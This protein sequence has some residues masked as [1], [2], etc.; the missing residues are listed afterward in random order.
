M[1]DVPNLQG[2]KL[3]CASAVI[4]VF[5][6]IVTGIVLSSL[7]R[8]D[9]GNVG[10]YFKYGALMDVTTNPGIHYMSPFV[11]DV[12]EVMIRPQTD[13]LP[14]ISAIT[15]DGIQNTFND[16]QVISRIKVKQL[17]PMI[18]T[19]GINFRD[20]LINDR[21]KEELRIF[22]ANH[23]IDD[24]YK[25]KF[26]EIAPHVKNNL[27]SS[28][29]RLGEG[30]IEILNLVI[31]K[32]QIPLDIANNYKQVKVQWT[33]QLVASQQQKTEAIKKETEKLKAIAD[34]E[35]QKDVLEINIQQ[36]ILEREGNKN[37]SA[38]ENQ[39]RKEKEENIANIAKY[40]AEKEAES[41]KLLYTEQYVKLSMA[42]AMSQNSKI[43]FSGQNS[44]LGALLDKIFDKN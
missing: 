18:K 4:I 9:E 26:L 8:I 29:Q 27:I 28:I 43:Y 15:K 38:I 16:V 25:V 33:Q 17:I 22:C 42:K 32:P 7:H 20:A 30:G 34:A 5:L 10:I 35:R 31:P 11:V 14:P 36:Q 12:Q 21:V 2:N 40:K 1:P 44:E 13:T 23:T 19:Y 39:I 24:V 6:A 37:I 3:K 41:N